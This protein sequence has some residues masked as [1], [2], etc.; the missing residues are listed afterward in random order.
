MI[1]PCVICRQ[2]SLHGA[3]LVCAITGKLPEASASIAQLRSLIEDDWA[4]RRG[5]RGRTAGASEGT[6]QPSLVVMEVLEAYIAAA[7]VRTVFINSDISIMGAILPII[8][9]LRDSLTRVRLRFGHE[10]PWFTAI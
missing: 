4:R 5:R 8:I 7:R 2:S 6:S 1:S 9:F 3:A 10:Q